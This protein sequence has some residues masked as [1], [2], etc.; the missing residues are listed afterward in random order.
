MLVLIQCAE[1]K[2]PEEAGATN[3]EL[4][5][6]SMKKVT[7]IMVHDI[8]SPP[9]ASR[10]YGYATI[11]AYE[12]IALNN[13]EYLSLAGQVNELTKGPV[14]ADEKVVQELASVHAFLTVSDALVFS[15]ELLAEYQD[16]LYNSLRKNGL[17]KD[18]FKASV[19]YGEEIAAH[20]MQWANTDFYNETRG[21]EKFPVLDEPGRWIPTP[22]AY[23]DAIEPSW[24]KIRPYALQSPDQFKPIPPYPFSLDKDSEFFRQTMEVYE[25]G[26]NLT[27]EE[28]EIAKFWDCNPFAMQL[29]GH[30][31]FSIKKLTPGGHWMGIAGIAAKSTNADFGRTSETYAKTAIALFDGFISSWDEK[32]RSNLIRPETVINQHIDPD[33][34]PLLQTP[35]FPE[36]TSGHSVISRAAAEALTSLYGD[37][38]YFED[39]TEVEY[40]LP[41]R[42]FESFFEAS[43]E[44]AVSRLYGGI[45][46][47]M[48]ADNGITQGEG[49]GKWVVSELEFGVE[50]L[51]EN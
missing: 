51:A 3:P 41:V 45:H 12:T 40:G 10:V 19:S 25:I 31:M 8:F 29:R 44:A 9:V 16:S 14:I 39:T 33:W 24:N 34:V 35:P 50:A 1:V 23:M 37:Q 48:A 26:Q 6:Q 47:R 32:F 15:N 49:V 27:E 20:I 43:D 21:T 38:F 46:Y 28:I 18:H 30:F 36:Y 17:S 2:S 22:P 11:A 4:L 5:H 13:P 7:D 42:T